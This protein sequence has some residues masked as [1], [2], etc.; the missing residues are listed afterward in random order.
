MIN[1]NYELTSSGH[2][3]TQ[4]PY[5]MAKDGSNDIKMVG[6]FDCYSCQYNRHDI[7]DEENKLTCCY[8][9]E[10]ITNYNCLYKDNDEKTRKILEKIGWKPFAEKY[11]KW[12]YT[13]N[14]AHEYS[15][16]DE[17][18][19]VNILKS[20]GIENSETIDCGSN[21]ALFLSIA[22]LIFSKTDK[23]KIFV[24]DTNQWWIN[25]G[26]T[27]P[28]GSLE[29]SLTD[30][31]YHGEPRMFTSVITPAHLASVSEL[32]E[33]CKDEDKCNFINKMFDRILDLN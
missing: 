19:Y 3:L 9:D 26:L 24:S 31:R 16:C 1:I 23:F 7:T 13:D 14:I 4:C 32:I 33:I 15:S 5:K 2:S 10:F 30:D 17:N 21:R 8:R 22:S 29:F 25:Q 6:S 20:D 18:G 27:M 12:L 28:K 11:N